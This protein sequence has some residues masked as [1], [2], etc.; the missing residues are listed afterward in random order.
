MNAAT[1]A[2]IAAWNVIADVELPAGTKVT[3]ED[4]RVTIRP[5]GGRP[6]RAT[7]GPAD[8]LDSLCNALKAAARAAAQDPH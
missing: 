7:Y 4:G 1:A 2:R 6:V 8:T 5:R 3:V